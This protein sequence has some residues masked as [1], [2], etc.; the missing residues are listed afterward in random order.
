MHDDLGDGDVELGAQVV[1]DPGLDPVAAL[2]RGA[3]R[4][5]TA[6]RA[7]ERRAAA[8]PRDRPPSRDLVRE[9]ARADV[10]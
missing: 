10:P 3:A 4:A 9:A 8:A 2:G 7:G 1:E 6:R 5:T